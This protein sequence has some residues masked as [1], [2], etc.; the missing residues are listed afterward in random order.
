[1]RYQSYDLFEAG[2]QRMQEMLAEIMALFGQGVLEH[3]PVRT[4]DVRRGTEAF[5]FLREGRNTGK[6]VLTVPAPLDPDGTVLIT[7]GTGGLG[8]LVARHLAKV[9][10]ARRLLLVSRRGQAAEGAGE[11]AAELEGLGARVRVAACDVAERHQL[12]TL[13][14]SLEHPLT[15]VVHAAGVL[16]DGLVESLTAEQIERVM[17]P[18]LD[19]AVHLDELTAEMELSS[20]VLFSSVA[21][22]IGS[23]GQG[24]YAAANA[25]LDALAAQRRSAGRPVTSLAWG[26]WSDAT[27]MTGGLEEAQLARL[28]RTGFAPLPTELSLELFDQARQLGQALVVPVRLDLA[29]LRA[30]A[31]AGMLPALLR[32]LVR[33]PVRQAQAAG[34]SLAQR[35]AGVPQP[36][37]ER[38]TLEFVQAHVAAVLGHASPDAVDPARPFR[39]LGFDSLAA[40]ELRNRLTQA[41]GVRLPTTL[42]FDHPTLTAVAQLLCTEIGAAQEAAPRPADVHHD[43]RGTFS[44]LLRQAHAQGSIVAALPLLTEASRFRP[45]FASAAELPKDDGYVVRLASGSGR[46]KLV[47]VPSFMVGSGPHQFMRFADH[48]EGARDVLACSLPGFRGTDPVP[49]SWD[50]AIEVLADSIRRAVDGAPFALVGYSIGGVI[51]HSIAARLAEADTD[52]GPAAI[53]MIDTPTPEGKEETNSIFSQVMTEILEREHG[54]SSAADADWLAMGTYMRLLAE[55]RPERTV[56]PT[57]LIRAG[58]PLGEGGDASGWP[59]WDISDDQVEIAADHFALIEAAAVATAEATERWLKQ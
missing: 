57:L 22:L 4:W 33:T 51:A 58:E 38:V 59:G 7:G 49:G 47:C 27:G 48:F 40:V 43:G 12:E 32:G 9:H 15:A 26:L 31:R 20:F 1:V 25:G 18:K 24:N 16:A 17:R 56:A 35:L 28:A 19:A 29:A 39:E 14:G 13:I 2:P 10:G 8:A 52:A 3:A 30:Q 21:A 46:P 34:G 50:A 11:L 37:R 54:A 42:V 41:A 6:V 53:V 44:G 45:A 36:D 23:P 5:R 55:R